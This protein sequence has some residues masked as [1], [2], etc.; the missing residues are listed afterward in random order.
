[1]YYIPKVYQ[2]YVCIF[3]VMYYIPT[4]GIQ[5]LCVNR[6]DYFIYNYLNYLRTCYM[7]INIHFSRYKIP[8]IGGNILNPVTIGDTFVQITLGRTSHSTQKH[9]TDSHPSP[10]RRPLS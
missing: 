1:M 3:V 8:N 2:K 4:K 10:L 7:L 6:C 9:R 5:K